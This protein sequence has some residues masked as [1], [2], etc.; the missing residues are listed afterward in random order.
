MRLRSTDPSTEAWRSSASMR[1]ARALPCQSQS[2]RAR[3]RGASDASAATT[4]PSPSISREEGSA[5]KA[6]GVLHW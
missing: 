2:M 1:A 3:A 6:T 5:S 4:Q